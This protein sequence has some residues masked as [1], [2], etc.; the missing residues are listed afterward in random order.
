MDTSFSTVRNPKVT[1]WPLEVRWWYRVANSRQMEQKGLTL[2]SVK[3][4]FGNLKCDL[5]SL[6]RSK[7]A[8][9]SKSVI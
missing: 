8:V 9:S 5:K 1:L 6:Y 3:I 2:L 7:W 4:G